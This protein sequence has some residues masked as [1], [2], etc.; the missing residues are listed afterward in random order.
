MSRGK[1]IIHWSLH[2]GIAPLQLLAASCR[3]GHTACLPWL[4]S[5]HQNLPPCSAGCSATKRSA[6]ADPQ[7]EEQARPAKRARRSAARG[8]FQ[9]ATDVRG[10]A[11]EA[12]LEG[13]R[14]Q[15]EEQARHDAEFKVGV[16]L[17]GTAGP[18]AMTSRPVHS[19]RYHCEAEHAATVSSVQRCT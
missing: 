14:R 17:S 16:G 10:A 4:G 12:R 18:S 5:R 13:I 1:G 3:R 7:H 19:L 15:Q 9:L 6:A 2:A 11:E 8:P